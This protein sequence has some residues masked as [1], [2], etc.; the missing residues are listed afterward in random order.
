MNEKSYP[1]SYEEDGINPL[2]R[3]ISKNVNNKTSH[4]K[5]SKSESRK[6]I[7][8][9]HSISNLHSHLKG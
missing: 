5:N 1:N 7:V 3:M 6:I 8:G 4:N 2:E 9:V